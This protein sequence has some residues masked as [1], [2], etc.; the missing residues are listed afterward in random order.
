[1]GLVCTGGEGESTSRRSEF[2]A[3]NAELFV[4]PGRT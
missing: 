1:M 2:A 3:R 4:G